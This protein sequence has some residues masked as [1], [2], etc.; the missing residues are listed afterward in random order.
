MFLEFYGDDCKGRSFCAV[1]DSA[2]SV[3]GDDWVLQAGTI[4]HLCAA[5][6]TFTLPLGGA[7]STRCQR[8]KEIV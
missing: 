1:Q 4:T 6:G 2:L 5:N 7:M 3:F 8:S